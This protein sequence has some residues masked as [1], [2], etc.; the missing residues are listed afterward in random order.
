MIMSECI[1]RHIVVCYSSHLEYRRRA[2]AYQLLL[3]RQ[4]QALAVLLGA[5]WTNR[6]DAHCQRLLTLTVHQV[7]ATGS[8]LD[9]QIPEIIKKK[10]LSTMY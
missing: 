5:C 7:L 1:Y 4:V 9:A 3:W 6:A 8:W 2:R 10:L